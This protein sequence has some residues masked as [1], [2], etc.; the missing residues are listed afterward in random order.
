MVDP[1]AAAS[2]AP[3]AVTAGSAPYPPQKQQGYEC[4]CEILAG[5]QSTN[6]IWVLWGCAKTKQSTYQ[7]T[8]LFKH[9]GQGESHSQQ[10][11]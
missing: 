3:D 6:A 5:S 4:E 10:V 9:Y 7:K 11:E 2:A 1:E 8:E